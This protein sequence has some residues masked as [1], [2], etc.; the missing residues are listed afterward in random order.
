M[1]GSQGQDHAIDYVEL[2]VPD[3]E[4]TQRFYEQAFGW[5]FTGYGPE[6]AG[7]RTPGGEREAGGLL[8]DAAGPRPGGP[9]VLLFATDLDRTLA[10][11]RA[12]GGEVVQ[13]PYPF[14]GG[15]RFHFRDPAG[16]E[17]GVWAEG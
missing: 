1:T 13:G 5:V 4:V 14:P 8:L 2:T 17:L 10:A 16:N 9:L 6:Y 15:R 11:V 7:F 3:I 12:A